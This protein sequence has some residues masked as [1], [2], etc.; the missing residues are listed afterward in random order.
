MLKIDEP[1]T[2]YTTHRQEPN[3]IDHIYD[4]PKP[5]D[6]QTYQMVQLGDP[7]DAELF[8]CAESWIMESR[9]IAAWYLFFAVDLV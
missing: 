3:R 9:I 4:L 5:K 8:Q 7:R 2:T 6:G 1:T